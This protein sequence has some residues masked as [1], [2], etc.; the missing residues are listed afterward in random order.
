MALGG[1]GGCI[2]VFVVPGGES[3][4]TSRALARF[5]PYTRW[6][7]YCDVSYLIREIDVARHRIEPALRM[8]RAVTADQARAKLAALRRV[9]PAFVFRRDSSVDFPSAAHFILNEACHAIRRFATN[10]AQL[11]SI[12]R[13]SGSAPGA[14]LTY[15][16]KG[17]DHE[18]CVLRSPA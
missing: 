3:L 15:E 11:G 1:A 2:P 4:P 17:G 7:D 18:R 14:D 16:V 9:R 5:L 6:L 12:N 13:S 8:L 10:G